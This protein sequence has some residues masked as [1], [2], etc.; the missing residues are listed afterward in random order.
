MAV[1]RCVSTTMFHG[2]T[3]LFVLVAHYMWSSRDYVGL[4]CGAFDLVR[5]SSPSRCANFLVGENSQPSVGWHL[6]L[7]A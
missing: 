7:H 1:R 2:I 3:L 4:C 5:L 6:D